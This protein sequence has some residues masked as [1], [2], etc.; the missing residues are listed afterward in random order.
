MLAVVA[1]GALG[2]DP[3]GN[4]GTIKIDDVPFDSHPN[5]EPHVGCVFQVDFYGFDK[6]PYNAKVT[7]QLQPP[8]GRRVLRTDTVFIGEDAA[9]GGTDLDAERTYDLNLDVMRSEFHP[10]QGWHIEVIVEAPGAGG[11]IARKSKVFWAH[12]CI[13]P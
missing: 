4:N 9:G 6:G 11:K 10:K 3:K 5:N 1:T 13:D 12:D 7:F 2:A 8:S